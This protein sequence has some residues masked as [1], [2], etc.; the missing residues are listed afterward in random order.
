MIRKTFTHAYIHVAL[1]VNFRFLKKGEKCNTHIHAYSYKK[2][3]KTF[4]HA[5]TNVFCMM[6][7]DLIEWFHSEYNSS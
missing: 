6:T 2:Q 3:T 1:F 5:H 7:N 4:T